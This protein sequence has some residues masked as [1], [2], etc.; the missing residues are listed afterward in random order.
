[1]GAN[2]IN[3]SAVHRYFSGGSYDGVLNRGPA[4]DYILAQ[5]KVARAHEMSATGHVRGKIVLNVQ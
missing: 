5:W 3:Q 4:R 2:L 1:M